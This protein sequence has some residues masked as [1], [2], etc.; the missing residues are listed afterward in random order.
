M[1]GGNKNK[2]ATLRSIEFTN[3][4]CFKFVSFALDLSKK[5]EKHKFFKYCPLKVSLGLYRVLPLHGHHSVTVSASVLRL[6]G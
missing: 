6:S 4:N 2:T 3:Q 1:L 5:A